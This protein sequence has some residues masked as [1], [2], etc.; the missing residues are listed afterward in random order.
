MIIFC[1]SIPNALTA[2]ECFP[3]ACCIALGGSTL[4]AKVK[5]LIPYIAD[6]ERAIVCVD[7]DPASEKMLR[8]IVEIV[9]PN[10]IQSFEWERDD[11]K[12]FDINDLLKAGQKERIIELIQNA[13]IVLYKGEATPDESKTGVSIGR[14]RHGGLSFS[15]EVLIDYT[16]AKGRFPKTSFPWHVLPESLVGSLKQLARSCAGSPTHLPGMV[17]GILAAVLGR[18]IEVLVKHS[19]AEPLIFWF[20]C[21]LPSGEGKTPAQNALCGPLYKEQ[22]KLDGMYREALAQW[23]ALPR[24]EQQQTPRP[25]SP[26]GIYTT[27]MTLEGIRKDQRSCGGALLANDEA[28]TFFD[29]QNQYKSGGGT[30]GQ[31]LLKLYDGKPARVVRSSGAASI[32]GSRVSI[33]GGSQ[34][35]V[36][37]RIFNSDGEG[38]TYLV[39][40]TIFRFMM[41]WEGEKF[42]LMTCEPWDEVNQ[43]V[44]SGLIKH[45]L[46]FCREKTKISD[47]GEKIETHQLWFSESALQHFLEWANDIKS[48]RG[49]LPEQ[50]RGYI[51][52]L[53]GWA[54]RLT[55]IVRC[56]DAFAGGVTVNQ[57]LGVEDLQK[58]ILLAEFYMGHNIEV[59]QAITGSNTSVKETFTEQEICLAQALLKQ[60]GSIDN[61]RLAIGFILE[62]FNKTCPPEL[63]LKSP[64]AMGSLIRSCQLTIL[65]GKHDANGKRAVNCLLWDEKTESYTET[66]LQSLQSLH[67]QEGEGFPDA[68]IENPMSAMS[69]KNINNDAYTHNPQT[70]QTLKNQC[71]HDGMPVNKGDADIA[72]IADVFPGDI[73]QNDTSDEVII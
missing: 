71:L 8:A 3:G 33:I 16:F 69:A 56:L 6:A 24:K 28:T 73:L 36:L 34:P 70:L 37:F 45:A 58:G 42:F 9:G 40:G 26:G 65:G 11:P 14:G 60:K 32:E 13:K 47:D 66:C 54:I 64:R 22:S 62:E 43:S 41:T 67:K 53:I 50:T 5:A 35:G 55:G 31:E 38:G 7:N 19:W 51:S 18:H 21:L 57:L 29:G 1:E 39:D 46:I 49:Q 68:D 20:M 48:I 72:D 59:M 27:N 4:T 12:G 2:S 52:K 15:P 44:W 10:K 17:F 23:E 30:D 61:G 63:Q 25:E